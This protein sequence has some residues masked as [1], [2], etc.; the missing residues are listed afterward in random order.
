[1]IRINLKK[2][3]L[4]KKLRGE[5]EYSA[6][7]NRKLNIVKLFLIRLRFKRLFRFNK[8]RLKFLYNHVYTSRT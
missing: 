8:V 1:M 5:Y 6:L 7:L 4:L 2:N 3:K